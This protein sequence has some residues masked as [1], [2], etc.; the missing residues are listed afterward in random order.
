[1]QGL[2]PLFKLKLNLQN[3]GTK[4]IQDLEMS[5]AANPILYKLKCRVLHVRAADESVC[6]GPASP[7][8]SYL[9]I[10]AIIAAAEITGA[11]AIH[12][13][14]GFLSE[15]PTFA[16][17]SA[18]CGLVFIGPSPDSMRLWGDKVRAREVALRYGLPLLP[19]TSVLRDAAHAI[20]EAGA[21]V[22]NSLSLLVRAGSA[23][24]RQLQRTDHHECRRRFGPSKRWALTQC[25]H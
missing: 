14:Y 16:E 12:P 13:G 1:V 25:T 3:M 17:V 9:H 5:F 23:I 7:R 18:Q 4:P 8:R 6:I 15:N 20:E 2:G 21:V 11:E 10:P 19:G 24:N 22:S